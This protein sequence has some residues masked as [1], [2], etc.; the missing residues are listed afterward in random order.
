MNPA[1]EL[2]VSDSGNQEVAKVSTGAIKTVAGNGTPNYSGD[3]ALPILNP[4]EMGQKEKKEVVARL[5][6]IPEIVEQFQRVFGRPPNWDDM[7]KALAAFERTR[8]STEAPALW[9]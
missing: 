3:A 8:L 4:I 5:A 9:R 1:G 2:Y 7:G 6:A